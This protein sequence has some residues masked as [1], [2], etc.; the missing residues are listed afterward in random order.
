MFGVMFLKNYTSLSD[1]KLIERINTDWAM[2][3]FCGTLLSDHE[4]IKEDHEQI[5]DKVIVSR[6]KSKIGKHTNK[7]DQVQSYDPYDLKSLANW[8][9]NAPA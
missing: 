6:I 4:Q 7:L 3:L 8:K 1:E 2:Q 9:V 5:K